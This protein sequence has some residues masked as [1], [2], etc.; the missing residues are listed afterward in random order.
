MR[1]LIVYVLILGCLFIFSC[2]EER[3]GSEAIDKPIILVNLQLRKANE[4]KSAHV[5]I[6]YIRFFETNGDQ[7]ETAI[8]TVQDWSGTTLDFDLSQAETKQVLE[9]PYWETILLGI[10]PNFIVNRVTTIDDMQMD[11]FA[12]EYVEYIPF[13]SQTI[14]ENGKQYQIDLTLDLDEA[15]IQREEAFMLKMSKIDAKISEL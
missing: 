8:G 3:M 14:I 12:V 4:W 6:D 7:S 2:S 5:T 10:D 1:K 15:L 9:E 11:E 13:D